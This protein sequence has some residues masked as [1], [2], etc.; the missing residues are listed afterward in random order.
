MSDIVLFGFGP[1]SSPTTLIIVGIVALLL[2]GNR[3]PSVMRSLGRSVVEFKKGV[4]GIEEDIDEAVRN[5]DDKAKKE[6]DEETK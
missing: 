3:L 4:N 5:A 6:L 2:F 1:V